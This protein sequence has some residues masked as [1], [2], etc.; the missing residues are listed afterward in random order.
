MLKSHTVTQPK[1]PSLISAEVNDH[2]VCTLVRQLFNKITSYL[3][4]CSYK[5]FLRSHHKS[6]KKEEDNT[7]DEQV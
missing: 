4:S 2:V 5:A 7:P 6:T 1:L 3:K